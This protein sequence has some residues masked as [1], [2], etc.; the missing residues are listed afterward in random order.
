MNS[1]YI[2]LT[3]SVLT[4]S[5]QS[6]GKMV[7]S[8]S[9]MAE[10]LPGILH[11]ATGIAVKSVEPVTSVGRIYIFNLTPYRHADPRIIVTDLCDMSDYYRVWG[12]MARGEYHLV[13][14]YVD[15]L[16]DSKAA[17]EYT[18]STLS[19]DV[20]AEEKRFMM[21]EL[22]KFRNEVAKS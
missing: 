4:T 17:A 8:P 11:L 2:R 10:Y 20:T 6:E 22:M 12:M 19:P 9:E 13:Y 3:Q 14:E 5:P 21:L 16:E 15:K 1:T 7:L 18:F